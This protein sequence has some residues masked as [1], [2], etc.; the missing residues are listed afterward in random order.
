VFWSRYVAAMKQKWARQHPSEPALV[1]VQVVFFRE[2]IPENGMEVV[3]R[4][5]L[6][7]LEPEASSQ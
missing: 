4:E 2:P 1:S 6:W 3:E 5:Q 7:P